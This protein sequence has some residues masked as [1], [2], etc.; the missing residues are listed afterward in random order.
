MSLVT[1]LNVGDTV[2]GTTWFQ[3]TIQSYYSYEGG[4]GEARARTQVR[5]AN[6]PWVPP[7][8]LMISPA[9]GDLQRE[10]GD[11]YGARIAGFHGLPEIKAG[12]EAVP[13]DPQREFGDGYGSLCG[14]SRPVGAGDQKSEFDGSLL[15]FVFSCVF[16]DLCVLWT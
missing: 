4:A 3:S 8:V 13:G 5:T 2:G 10:F 9:P 14:S 7:H 15:R 16:L 12:F 1:K 6:T 11:G